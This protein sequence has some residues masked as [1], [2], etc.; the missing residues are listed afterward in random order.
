[1]EKMDMLALFFVTKHHQI[2]MFQQT[3]ASAIPRCK[4]TGLESV[5]KKKKGK[6]KKIKMHSLNIQFSLDCDVLCGV[7]ISN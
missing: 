3:I 1:M 4:Q 2:N 7:Y 6:K 5:N